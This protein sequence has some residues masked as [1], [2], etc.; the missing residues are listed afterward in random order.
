MRDAGLI[1]DAVFEESKARELGVVTAKGR[2]NTYYAGFMELVQRQL[3]TE[4]DE[5][6]LTERGLKI[7]TTLDTTVQA[8]AEEALA[9]ETARLQR[10]RPELEGAVVVTSPNSAEVRALVGSAR[11][12]PV[13][14]NRA[15]DA[16]RQVGSLIKPV[17]Y[18]AAL[19]SGRHS[20]AT[21]IADEPITLEIEKGQS[22][23]PKNIDDEEHG[24]VTVVR[25]LAESMNLATVRL[26][27]DVGLER[28]AATLEDLGTEPPRELYPSLLL[29]AIELTP[30]EAAQLYNTIANGG[31]YSPL[32]A[33]H[34]VVD[35][36]GRTLQRYSLAIEQVAEPV[37][38]YALNQA[39]VQVMERGT[40]RGARQILPDRLRVAGK[41]GTSDDLRDSWFAGFSSDYLTVAWIGNDRNEPVG[42]TGGAGAAQ[43][44]AR[45][46]ARVATTPYD[47]PPPEGAR[48][49]WID[50]DTGLATDANCP[51][52]IS[53]AIPAR[54][55]PPKAAD[56]GGTRARVGG[57]LRQWI[58][59]RLGD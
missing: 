54:Q 35:G 56:C 47:A 17:V 16:R 11:I 29:G 32:R 13:G 18:L 26:G 49:V 40:G 21:Q 27:L 59:N 5:K 48:S 4:Y 41:T 55:V 1:D 6:E 19:Q 7:Y 31:F 3:R 37:S 34:S 14:F 36:A 51:A 12:G 2:N 30:I 42:L 52:A 45:V 10:G 38:V 44:W 24:Q 46:M 33:V 43:V 50:Y 15:L 53:V 25:A 58:R 22:W 20:L 23:S 8:A 9:A 57:R 28:V 39:L